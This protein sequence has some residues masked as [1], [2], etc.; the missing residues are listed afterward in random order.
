[1]GGQQHKVYACPLTLVNPSTLRQG[2]G[3]AS[4]RTR[5]LASSYSYWMLDAGCWLLV[6]LVIAMQLVVAASAEMCYNAT[7]SYQTI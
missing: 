1:M 2:S 6:V 5:R 4:L 3:Q 7:R